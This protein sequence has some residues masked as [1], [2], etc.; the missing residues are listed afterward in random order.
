MYQQ[1]LTDAVV[2]AASFTTENTVVFHTAN[3]QD[4]QWIYSNV[5]DI[6]NERDIDKTDEV[7]LGRNYYLDLYESDDHSTYGEG[8]NGWNTKPIYRVSFSPTEISQ[9]RML[10]WVDES[11]YG[12][13]APTDFDISP[14]V[15]EMIYR[16]GAHEMMGDEEPYIEFE[17]IDSQRLQAELQNLD[18][19]TTKVN[20]LWRLDEENSA[21]FREYAEI[22]EPKGG[23]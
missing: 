19:R 20:G 21:K 6:S 15:A 12:F 14:L 11:S 22:P 3:Q 8:M 17:A 10:N 4:A 1:D 23:D 18:I 5:D 2:V 7:G 16:A 9:Q 13:T